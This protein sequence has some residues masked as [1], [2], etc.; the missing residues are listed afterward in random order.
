MNTLG[1]VF[2][3]SGFLLGRQVVTGR[4]RETPTDI[5]DM[6]LALLSGDFPAITETLSRRGENAPPA[7]TGTVAA[8]TAGGVTELLTQPVTGNSDLLAK[9]TELGGKAKGYV[10]GATG[11][12]YYDCSGLV[13]QAM[14]Q[15]GMYNGPRFTTRS[16]V[17]QMGSRATLVDKPTVGDVVLW[18]SRHMGIVSGKDK[19][20]S[21]MSPANGIG[22]G[23][24]SASTPTIG[25]TPVYYRIKEG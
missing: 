18:P 9:A 25:G 15:I 21:A 8:A 11:P 4:V 20:Y 19:M 12:D 1:L 13:W 22:Y 2:I 6:T 17:S 23:T 3:L 16:F 5:R 7:V 10:L 24:I 14:K